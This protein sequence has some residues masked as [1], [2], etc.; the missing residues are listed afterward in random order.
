M[1]TTELR[2]LLVCRRQ[3]RGVKQHTASGMLSLRAVWYSGALDAL[4]A[5]LAWLSEA[6]FLHGV[7]VDDVDG[8]KKERD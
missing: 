6:P 4:R 8:G 2:L 5:Q 7:D 1:V 3:K